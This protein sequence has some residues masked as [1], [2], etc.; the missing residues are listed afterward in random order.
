MERGDKG[1]YP[2][3]VQ[4]KAKI[5]HYRQHKRRVSINVPFPV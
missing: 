2:Q 5:K 1:N 3:L 4:A